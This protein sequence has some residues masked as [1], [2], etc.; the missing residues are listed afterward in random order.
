MIPRENIKSSDA[1]IT[2]TILKLS[3]QPADFLVS[4]GLE[5]V[6]SAPRALPT[7][8]LGY[9]S[10]TAL[11]EEGEIRLLHCFDTKLQQYRNPINQTPLSLLSMHQCGLNRKLSFLPQAK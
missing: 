11:G 7:Y 3:V 9:M 8:G 5:G 1:Q 4:G 2:G 6:E 10:N